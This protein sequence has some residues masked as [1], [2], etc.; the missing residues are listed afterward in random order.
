MRK[1]GLD[2]RNLVDFAAGME[3]NPTQPPLPFNLQALQL[4][5][6]VGEG[7]TCPRPTHLSPRRG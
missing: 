4:W 1:R 5:R 7:E 6:V 3:L 2:V